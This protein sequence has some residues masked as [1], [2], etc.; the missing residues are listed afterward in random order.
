MC[1]AAIAAANPM[2]ELIIVDRDTI[3]GTTYDWQ[4]SGPAIQ[5]VVNDPVYG[6]H[7]TWM[8]S[9]A[10][11]PYPDRD[12]RYNFF[13]R[14]AGEWSW[15][16]PVNYMNSGV[17]CYGGNTGYGSIDVDPASGVAYISAHYPTYPSIVRDAAPGAGVFEE[18]GGPPNCSAF[19]WPVSAIS[20]NGTV[21]SALIDAPSRSQ[22]YY[23]RITSWGAWSAPYYIS[24]SP[25]VDP[26]YPS[27]NIAVSHQSDLAII[28]WTDP[29]QDNIQLFLRRSTDNGNSWADAESLPPPPAFTPGSDT[30]PQYDLTG[31][32]VAFDPDD[33]WHLVTTVIPKVH[34]VT[35][36]MPA[37]IWHYSPAQTPQWSRVRR[38]ECDTLHLAGALGYAAV[39]A[40]RPSI[41]FGRDNRCFVVWEEFD[42]MNVEPAT[43]RLRADIKS[44]LSQ[45]NGQSWFPDEGSSIT[46]PDQTSKRFPFVAA[47]TN[48]DTM[49]IV[50]EQDLQAGFPIKNEGTV[51]DNPIVYV[52]AVWMGSGVEERPVSAGKPLQFRATPNPFRDQVRFSVDAVGSA[53]LVISDV[54]GRSVRE[55]PLD[56]RAASVVWDGRNSAGTRL[57]AGVYF[58]KLSAG[59]NTVRG[60]MLMTD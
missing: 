19:V 27:H 12:K 38:A 42:S 9:A 58:Y 49:H 6:I 31:A 44:S 39:Y 41:A 16:D 51:T 8:Y 26:V 7:A 2:P 11:G 47:V 23:S 54:A 3:G 46:L 35:Y 14:T 20:G 55:L 36:I 37:E 1:L 48:G 28:T 33:N 43:E 21:H 52:R 25:G 57:P 15:K 45:D 56:G 13:D 17:N 10:T 18:C 50:Y 34:D 30:V 60:K 22:V 53:R 59:S 24:V 29:M 32:Y 4:Q 40:C 5:T